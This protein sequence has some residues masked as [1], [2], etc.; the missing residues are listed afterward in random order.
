ME[1][2]AGAQYYYSLHG[3]TLISSTIGHLY[4]N[5]YK[6]KF[7]CCTTATPLSGKPHLPWPPLCFRVWWCYMK[8]AVVVR[9]TPLRSAILLSCLIPFV[10]LDT[11]EKN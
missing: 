4:E 9:G 3:P 5:E 10:I 1:V 11:R 8:W 2:I 7:G 6:A